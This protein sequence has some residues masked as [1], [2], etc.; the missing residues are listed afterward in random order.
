MTTIQIRTL[1]RIFGVIR[2]EP[3]LRP[4]RNFFGF[5][6]KAAFQDSCFLGLS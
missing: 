2:S 6:P 4:Q 3:D 1:S 5:R